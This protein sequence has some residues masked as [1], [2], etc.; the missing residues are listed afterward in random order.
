MRMT[1][2]TKIMLIACGSFN[3]CTPMHFRMFEIARDHFNQMG[4]A[5]VVGGIVSPVHDSYGKK[6]LVSASHRC[7][8]IKIG[9]Q[10]SDWVRL[11]DWETQQEEWTR[12]RLTLQYHQNYINSVL[13]DSNSINDQQIPS[14]L[15]EGLNKMTG[16][17]QLKLLCGAD[18]LESFATPGLWKDEDIEAIIGQHGLVVISRAGSNPEQFIFNSDLLSRYRRNITIVT[19]WVTND[20]SSTLVRRLLGRGLSVKYLLDDYVTE[21]IKKHLLYGSSATKFNLT[22]NTGV[23]VMSISPV[24]P[25]NDNE[26]Y[27]ECQNQLNT[28]NSESMDETDFPRNALNRVFCCGTE[29]D[30]K[31]SAKNMRGFLSAPGGAVQIITTKATTAASV[32]PDSAIDTVSYRTAD[33]KVVPKKLKLSAVPV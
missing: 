24:S 27:I 28:L 30:A 21:Y 4:T 18:L 17:V 23:E 15:P 31:N 33:E 26:D 3:P 10:S 2:P 13:K 9:L 29:N 20:V 19:N 5:E 8:M 32:T 7:T 25:V 1:A 14:W 11:S 22:P 12:T 16:H 6:G